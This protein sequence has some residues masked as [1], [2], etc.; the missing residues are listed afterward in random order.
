MGKKIA[1]MFPGQG[2]QKVG[3][4]Q[5]FYEEYEVVQQL[6][7]LANDALQFDIKELMFTGPAEKLTATE[8]AQPALVLSSI[9][10]YTILK[11]ENIVPDMVVGHSLGEYSALVAAGV[12]S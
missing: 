7:E 9:A 10:A 5:A 3:M 6:Y 11:Q 4:G 2:S 12:L 8:N 1:F